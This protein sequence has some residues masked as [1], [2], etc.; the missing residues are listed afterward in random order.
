MEQMFLD[1]GTR[2]EGDGVDYLDIPI[3]VQARSQ[4]LHQ[5]LWRATAATNEYPAAA[6]KAVV[7]GVRSSCQLALIEL[8]PV[9]L[10]HLQ[11]YL[12]VEVGCLHPL[13]LNEPISGIIWLVTILFK[14]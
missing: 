6:F 2:A 8:L 4:S 3:L 1:K 11:L 9:C 5:M 7:K 10:V 13:K 12:S 14:G